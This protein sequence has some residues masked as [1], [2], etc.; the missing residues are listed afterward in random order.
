M[1]GPDAVMHR[2]A[3]I[4]ADGLYRYILSRRWSPGH[5]ATFVM[6]NPSTADAEQDD[7]TI[8]RCIGFARAWGMG[9]MQV[10]NLYALRSP[11]PAAL[12]RAEDPIGPDNDAVLVACAIAHTDA[13]L[14]AAW[15]ANARPSRV[16]AVLRL[17]GMERLQALG[18]TKA[19]H[20]RHPLYVPATA[21]LRAW[22]A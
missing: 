3:E 16:A 19:G 13:P 6:L 17:P 14:V 20:P 10:V 9:A 21:Q 4:S 7:P 11:D 2:D 1:K 18:M 12:W 5:R 8:R 15:G 22:P